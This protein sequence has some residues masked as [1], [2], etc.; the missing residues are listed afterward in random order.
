ML[1][2]SLVVGIGVI[3]AAPGAWAEYRIESLDN[4]FQGEIAAA[5][6][7]NKYLVLFFHQAGCPYCDKMRAR[8]HPAPDVM[9]YYSENFVMIECDIKGN[10]D[11]VTPDGESM[12]E[13]EFAR[14]MRVRA[15]PVFVFYDKDGQ[16]ALR[17]TGYL[18]ER[19]FLLAGRYV[20]DGVYKSG[21]SFFR[22]A[23][24]AE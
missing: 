14:Q 10:L 9:A 5:A 15:T 7:E 20:V 4:D 23:Q 2:A 17:A 21:K 1:F 12:T 6:D 11:V 8:I 13:V 24:E 16:L 18:D 22:Y 3:L 19:V